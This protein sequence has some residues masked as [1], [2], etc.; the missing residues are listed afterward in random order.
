MEDTLLAPIYVTEETS[1]KPDVNPKH[2]RLY[3][4]HNCPF[5]EKVRL[6]F[7]AHNIVYQQCDVDLG[8]KTDWHKAINGGLVP[9]YEF[10][11]GT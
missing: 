9:I 6:A 3:G 7:A 8:K 4:H 5:V 1:P 11:D 10:P 2:P